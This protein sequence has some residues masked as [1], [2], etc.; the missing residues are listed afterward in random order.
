MD[1]LFEQPLSEPG[2]SQL[3]RV[4][5]EHPNVVLAR[6]LWPRLGNAQLSP[7]AEERGKRS[8]GSVEAGLPFYPE[9]LRAKP[10]RA[11]AFV[12]DEPPTPLA[13]VVAIDISFNEH[14]RDSM[15]PEAY[16]METFPIKL[17]ELS[18]R[19]SRQSPGG[20]LNE[21]PV[22]Y[23]RHRGLYWSMWH[24]LSLGLDVKLPINYVGDDE[25]FARLPFEQ[26]LDEETPIARVQNMIVI[27]GV[28]GEIQGDVTPLSAGSK[29]LTSGPVMWANAINSLLTNQ[30]IHLLHPW[31]VYG[32][33]CGYSAVLLWACRRKTGWGRRGAVSV[34]AVVGLI[35]AVEVLFKLARFQMVIMPYVMATVLVQIYI[36][37]APSALVGGRLATRPDD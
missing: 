6:T 14:I 16:W 17:V 10:T 1:F 30:Q 28:T 15:L 18:D 22:T 13:G 24:P 27:V 9:L 20:L 36:A 37:G 2:D 7:S 32:L 31:G 23:A 26:L 11:I 3:A 35:V 12:N 21:D 8:A 4:V 33:I 5:A 19:T 25:V 34:G 29:R